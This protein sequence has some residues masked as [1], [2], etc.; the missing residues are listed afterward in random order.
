MN[1]K[2]RR[3]KLTD[4]SV[5][6]LAQWANNDYADDYKLFY[7][8]GFYELCAVRIWES[9]AIECLQNAEEK[10]IRDVAKGISYRIERR[11]I[12]QALKDVTTVKC[13]SCGAY[14]FLDS[15]YSVEEYLT[16]RCGSCGEKGSL[17][18]KGE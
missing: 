5:E 7:E 2:I 1:K 11:M 14:H 3:P 13:E 6:Y 10:N 8:N 15:S 9:G 12:N 17:K 4:E 18:V 16:Y